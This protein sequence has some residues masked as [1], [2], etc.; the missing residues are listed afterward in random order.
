MQFTNLPES[1]AYRAAREELRLAE[2]ELTDHC[3]RVAALRRALPPGPVVPDYQFTPA[4]P[5][6][7]TVD[8]P[9]TVRLSELFTA[10]DRALIVYHLMFGKRQE[11][12][13]P[14]CTMWVDGFNGVARHVLQRVDFV[15]VAAADPVALQA[16][17][18]LRGWTSLQLLS[19]GDSS[20]KRDLGSEEDD[21][22]QTSLVSVFQK[23]REAVR[24]LYSARPQLSDER[25]ERGIDALCATWPLLDLTPNARGDWYASLDY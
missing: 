8:D 17:A 11:S 13:C 9:R 2:L 16:H 23:D 12:P 15:V 19:A 5:G 25:F 10:P 6:V 1:D 3:E 22:S 18:K 7:G 20:F 14:M 4:V 21:G 24:H